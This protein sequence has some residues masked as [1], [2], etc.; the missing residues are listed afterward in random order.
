[1]PEALIQATSQRVKYELQRRDCYDIKKVRTIIIVL[2][3]IAKRCLSRAECE[4]VSTVRYT[5]EACFYHMHG[6]HESCIEFF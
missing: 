2:E 6:K 5:F 1:M 4:L 3:I